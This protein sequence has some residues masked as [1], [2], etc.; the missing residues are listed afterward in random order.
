MREQALKLETDYVE[1]K[2]P[3]NY[4]S[5]RLSPTMYPD[6]SQNNNNESQESEM[7]V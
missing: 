4:Q 5:I 2:Y 3:M 6:L 1:S 7:L